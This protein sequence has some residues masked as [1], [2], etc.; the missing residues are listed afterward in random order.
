MANYYPL[1]QSYLLQQQQ[2]QENKQPQ[3]QLPAQVLSMEA[4]HKCGVDTFDL[5][6]C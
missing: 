6:H 5:L 4:M 2:H 3:P 1:V